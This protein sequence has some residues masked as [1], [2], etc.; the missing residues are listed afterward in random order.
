MKISDRI[1]EWEKCDVKDYSSRKKS[2]SH[3][4]SMGHGGLLPFVLLEK[5]NYGGKASARLRIQEQP[6]ITFVDFVEDL[7]KIGFEGEVDTPGIAKAI[8]INDPE[9]APGNWENE[10]GAPL[11]KYMI[12]Q[13]GCEPFDQQR[14]NQAIGGE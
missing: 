13:L 3:N 1:I 5:L 11:I 2:V 14:Y 4:T 9:N 6:N 12:V 8:F 10:P 7:A